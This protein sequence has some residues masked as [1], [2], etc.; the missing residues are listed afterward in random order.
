[1]SQFDVYANTNS[2]TKKAYPY[3]VDLQSSL[4]DDL[5][6]RIAAP[7]APFNKLKKQDMKRLTPVIDLEGK[8]F[9]LLIPQLSAIPASSLKSPIGTLAHMRTEIIDALDLAITG[10]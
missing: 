2:A 7:L 10:I 5:N 8:T 1:M 6:T 9:I 3:I 4:L